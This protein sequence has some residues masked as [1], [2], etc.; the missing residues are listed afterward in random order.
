MFKWQGGNAGE[1]GNEDRN[2]DGWLWEHANY[3]TSWAKAISE[4]E[5][6]RRTTGGAETAGRGEGTETA[7]GDSSQ[8]ERKTGVGEER[9]DRAV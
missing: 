7:A 9:T 3:M 8:R 5:G 6:G 1:S 4:I 2:S